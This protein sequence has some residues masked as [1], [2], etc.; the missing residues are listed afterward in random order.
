VVHTIAA[1]ITI[2]DTHVNIQAFGRSSGQSSQQRLT[3]I[4]LPFD[5][6]MRVH[7]QANTEE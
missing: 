1:N 2:A 4:D 7:V 3:V 5:A 6:A